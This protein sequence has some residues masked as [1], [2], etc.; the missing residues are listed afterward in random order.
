MA[1]RGVAPRRAC[2]VLACG[3]DP[4]QKQGCKHDDRQVP[5]IRHHVKAAVVTLWDGLGSGLPTATAPNTVRMYLRL[6]T[7]A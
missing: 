7:Y 6:P 5:Q 1:W 3:A 4:P 2:L